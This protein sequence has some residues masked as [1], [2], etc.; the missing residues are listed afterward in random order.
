MSGI[1]DNKGAQVIDLY[2]ALCNS[3]GVKPRT[4]KGDVVTPPTTAEG[5]VADNAT[6]DWQD[7]VDYVTAPDGTKWRVSTKRFDFDLSP[8]FSMRGP[9]FHETLIFAD[10]HEPSDSDAR[11]HFCRRYETPTDAT[12]GHA[13]AVDEVRTR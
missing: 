12:V 10:G 8:P 2:E 13:A 3:M 11:D 9:L 7:L 6:P 1:N 5:I 4:A